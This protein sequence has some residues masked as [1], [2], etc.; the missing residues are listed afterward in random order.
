MSRRID[1]REMFRRTGLSV[2]A[3]ALPSWLARGLTDQDGTSRTSIL[4]AAAARATRT[5][6]PLLVFVVPSESGAG[7]D[8]GLQFGALLNHCGPHTLVDGA[9]CEPCCATVAEIK[10]VFDGIRIEGEP[11]MACVGRS[12]DDRRPFALPI[13]PDYSEVEAEPKFAEGDDWQ[14]HQKAREDWMRKR[15]VCMETAIA[16]AV[17]QARDRIS[18]EP[19]DETTRAAILELARVDTRPNAEFVFEKASWIHDALDAETDRKRRSRLVSALV[20]A[21]TLK[22]RT[23]QL[24]GSKWANSDGCG[25]DIEGESK[26]ANFP[27]I[28]CGMAMMPPLSSRFVYF[29]SE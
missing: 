21:G 5:G 27:S 23:T 18:R 11:W 1:R 28:A 26:D 22:Y 20:A 6:K 9:T 15:V 12:E 4:R 3:L 7:Y 10:V 8:R 19:A 2:G 17:G 25:I 29:Y 13:E 16:S 14:K 24:P